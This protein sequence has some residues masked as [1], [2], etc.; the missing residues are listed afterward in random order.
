MDYFSC[1]MIVN[2]EQLEEVVDDQCT[3]VLGTV[4]GVYHVQK[5]LLIPQRWHKDTEG[6]LELFN[7]DDVFPETHAHTNIVTKSLRGLFES[8]V[9]SQRLHGPVSFTV[10]QNVFE[11]YKVIYI[12]AQ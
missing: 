12:T 10:Y 1:P 11:A 3:S 7:L 6:E 5:P 2:K 4:S 8:F 9:R